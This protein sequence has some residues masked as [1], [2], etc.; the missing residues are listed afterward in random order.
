MNKVEL[1]ISSGLRLRFDIKLGYN[2]RYF[3][4]NLRNKA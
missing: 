1:M 2:A 3:P 4:T